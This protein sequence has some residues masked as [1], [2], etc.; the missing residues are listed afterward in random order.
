[1]TSF[2]SMTLFFFICML[3]SLAVNCF[4]EELSAVMCEASGLE[5]LSLNGLGAAEGCENSIEFPFSGVSLFNTIGG[6]LPECV[7]HLPN[8]TALHLTG[9]ALTG[10]IISQLP[11]SSRIADLSL[12]HNKFSGNIPLRAQKIQRVDLSHNQFSGKYEDFEELWLNDF[13]DFK[14]NR[15]S[16]QLPVSKLENVSDLNILKGNMFSCESIPGNDGF[17]EDYICGSKDLD[18]SLYVFGSGLS[19]MCVV[20]L[21]V[22]LAYVMSRPASAKTA[23]LP[24]CVHD[25]IRRHYLFM[26]YIDQLAARSADASLQA[27]VSLH[28]KCSRASRLFAQLLC[29]V[30]VVASPVYMLRG[31]DDNDTFS[32]HANTYSWFWTLA[33]MRGVAPAALLLVSWAVAVTACFYRIVLV[34]AGDGTPPLAEKESLSL[35]GGGGSSDEEEARDVAAHNYFR[36]YGLIACV[37]IINAAIVATVN[38]LYIYSTQQPLSIFVLFCLQLSLAVFRLVYAYFVSPTFSRSIVDPIANIGFRLRLLLLNNLVIPCFVTAFASP[39]CF[40]VMNACMHARRVNV[41]IDF[42]RILFNIYTTVLQ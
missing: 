37:L 39:S 35:G 13:V 16:G 40:Q 8:L 33:Y 19:V 41:Y 24:P 21:L 25:H 20:A 9:N 34:P 1:M 6:T 10:N 15:L 11:D 3:V 5:V 31:S 12:S 26:T 22:C 7:W 14:I 18:E 42:S 17:V 23:L 29:V 30:L 2:I 32:T 36:T 28:E 38:V 4:R 27:I